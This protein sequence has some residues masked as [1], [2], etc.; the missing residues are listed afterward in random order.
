MSFIV[1]RR[2]LLVA[3]LAIAACTSS[4]EAAVDPGASQ[5]ADVTPSSPPTPSV[6]GPAAAPAADPSAKP[7]VADKPA[8]GPP[9]ADD[10]PRFDRVAQAGEGDA[11]VSLVQTTDGQVFAAAGPV[12]ARLGADGS[13]EREA[14]WVRGIDDQRGSLEGIT[15]GYYWWRAV[16]MGGTWPEGAYLVLSPESGGRGDLAWHETYRRTNGTWN[17]VDTRSKTFDW[18]VHSF[19]AWKDGSLLAL[20]AFSPRY[21]R[22]DDEGSAPAGEV[23]AAAKAI[24]REKK[25]IVL[26]GKPKAPPFG[27]RDVRAFASLGSGEIYAAMGEG[28]T[29]SILHHDDVTSSERR[30]E[31]PGN[32]AVSAHEI[33]VVATG[34]DRVWVF[35]SASAGDETRGYVATF[36]GRAWREVTTPCVAAAH[37]GSIDDAG[38]AYFICDVPRDAKDTAAALLRAR[39]NTVEELPTGIEPGT[40]VARTPTDIWV[41]SVPYARDYALV[42]T[43]TRAKSVQTLTSQSEAGRAVYEWADP[44]PFA[45]P[46]GGVWMPLAEG[47]DR[48]SVSKSLEGLEETGGYPEVYEARI[49]GRTAWGVTVHGLTDRKLVAATK[50]VIKRLGTAVGAPTCNQRPGVDPT[51]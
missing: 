46:C 30:F 11:F 18:H 22:F 23:K 27:E 24:A 25:L 35:G 26:R 12:V 50:G 48:E 40:V 51:L 16:S 39:D 37:S 5:S 31:L 4:E 14:P 10:A 42:H 47:A 43:G 38:S 19:G 36:D 32:V 9:V 49:Q 20:R 33:E 41:L 21:S 6:V 2:V 13:F 1:P 7:V 8:F 29:V 15:S 44:R 45:V 3:S 17:L 28:D 34:D